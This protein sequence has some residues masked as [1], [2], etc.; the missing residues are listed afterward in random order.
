MGMTPEGKIKK[1][2][3]KMLKGK[4]GVWSFPPQAGPFGSAGIPDRIACVH[5]HLLGIE[6]KADIMKKPT[7]LQH[8]CMSKIRAAGGT[9][10]VV[11]DDETIKLVEDWIDN[12][13]R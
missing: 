2:L 1:K 9:C 10:F 11:Y 4:P 8:Q 13:S 7:A 6:A 3:D 12:A 5:G